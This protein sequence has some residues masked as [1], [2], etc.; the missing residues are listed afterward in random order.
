MGYSGRLFEATVPASAILCI[1]CTAYY[2][3]SLPKVN[4]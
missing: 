3:S 4:A 1:T 2:F